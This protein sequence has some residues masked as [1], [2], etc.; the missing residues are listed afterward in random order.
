MRLCDFDALICD[1]DDVGESKILNGGWKMEI[2]NCGTCA[3]CMSMSR[4]V[5]DLGCWLKCNCSLHGMKEG[6]MANCGDY[7]ESGKDTCAGSDNAEMN[8]RES[9]QYLLNVMD[10][11]FKDKTFRRYIRHALDGDFACEIARVIREADLANN[12]L[13]NTEMLEQLAKSAHER[14]DDLKVYMDAISEN[15]LRHNGEIDTLLRGARSA[16]HA[17]VNGVYAIRRCDDYLEPWITGEGCDGSIRNAKRFESVKDVD[18][19]IDELDHGLCYMVVS[20]CDDWSFRHVKTVRPST[21]CR[22]G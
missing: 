10:E 2:G 22:Y 16:E 17:K 15:V 3:N 6:Y 8:V 1:Q 4:T 20:V 14:I 19:F 18:A 7:C 12:E 5:D 9:K 13:D 11:K 21:W